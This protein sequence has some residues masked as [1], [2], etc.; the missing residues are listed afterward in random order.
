MNSLHFFFSFSIEIFT[1]QPRTYFRLCDNFIRRGI[2]F[3]AFERNFKI[4]SKVELYRLDQIRIRYEVFN[5]RYSSTSL[6]NSSYT[7]KSTPIY[8]LKSFITPFF[9]PPTNPC[10]EF[11]H[12]LIASSFQNARRTDRNFI[13][14]FQA[15]YTGV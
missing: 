14:P 13:L 2:F 11:F 7:N 9:S 4:R 15:D 12:Q 3:F 1:N 5:H 10:P 6:S 8:I